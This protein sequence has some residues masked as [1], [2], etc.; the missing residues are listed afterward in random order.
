MD[1][2][3][4]FD[5]ALMHFQ[6]TQAPG[7]FFWKFLLAYLLLYGLGVAI[8]IALVGAPFLSLMQMAA[9]SPGGQLPEEDA[10]RFLGAMGMVYLVAIPLFAI[11]WAM[12]EG[13]LQRRYVRLE[14]FSLRFG[15]DELR[16]LAV[17]LFWML[18]FIALYIAM[19]I[20]IAVP[21][22]VVAAASGGDGAGAVIA[23]IFGFL[24]FLAGLVVFLVVAIRLS[25]AAAI[26]VRDR[27]ITFFGAWG[28]TK[29]RFWPL[30]GAFVILLVVAMLASFA[31][32]IVMGA[33]MA[34]AMM[35]NVEALEA[36]DAAGVFT[37]PTVLASFGLVLIGYT[38]LQAG[39]QFVSAGIPAHAANTDPRG[40]GLASPAP[41]FD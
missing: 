6:R 8:L 17:G 26:T 41:T 38:A 24:G 32:Q 29:N 27:K 28:A 31:L 19:V 9:Q 35:T 25:P 34:G 16:L 13:A 39:V 14:G 15:G 12:L 5:G 30:L 21:V 7:G 22:G 4:T 1:T 40:G 3:F 2:R 36:G 23:G 10:L 37:A 11:I 33:V 20:A 18:L